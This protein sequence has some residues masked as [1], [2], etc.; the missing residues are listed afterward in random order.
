MV[1]KEVAT[2]QEAVRILVVDDEQDLVWA[3]QHSLRDD[4]YEVFIACDGV[5]ALAMARRH[6]P[7]LIILDIVMPR[8]DGVSVCRILRRDPALG[9]VPIMFL[10]VRGDIES[11]VTGLNQGSDDYLVKPF[12]MLELKAHVRALLRR[13]QRSPVP[14]L[15]QDSTVVLGPLALDLR[16][17]QVHV[18]EK[19]MSLTP[20]EFDLLHYLMSHS[21]EV[22][23]SQALIQAVWGY[24]LNTAN[25]SLVRW[26]IKNLRAKLE[27]DPAHPVLIRTVPR[28]GYILPRD[29]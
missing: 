24:A 7:D 2:G 21:G 25:S 16:S 28:H 9:A 10:T 23:S 12:D 1:N 3:L 22:F 20:I 26:H 19:I 8:L 27:A 15:D 14:G 13:R 5:E 6:R 11:R 18:G 17:R 29:I 4:G